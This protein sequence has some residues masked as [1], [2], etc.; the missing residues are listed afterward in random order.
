MDM[1]QYVTVFDVIVDSQVNARFDQAL[2]LIMYIHTV[3]QIIAPLV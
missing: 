2:S 3:S 1:H